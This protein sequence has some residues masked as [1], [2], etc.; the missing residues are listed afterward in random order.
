MLTHLIIFFSLFQSKVQSLAPFV[1]ISSASYDAHFGIYQK[2]NHKNVEPFYKMISINQSYFYSFQNGTFTISDEIN[3]LGNFKLEVGKDSGKRIW[4][5]NN[6][7]IWEEVSPSIVLKPLNDPHPQN[8][9][10]TSSGGVSRHYPQFLG[11][12]TR[13]NNTEKGFPVYKER[14]SDYTFII[15]DNLTQLKSLITES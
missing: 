14:L 8:Y 5:V 15:C 1:N 7:N 4:F 2:L 6:S 11:S 12:Y 13:T 3:S 9:L 10:V